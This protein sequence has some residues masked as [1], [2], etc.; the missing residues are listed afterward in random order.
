MGALARPAGRRAMLD[1]LDGL[2][3]EDT[4]PLL[5][6]L[7]VLP[8]DRQRLLLEEFRVVTLHGGEVREPEGVH[9]LGQAQVLG[10]PRLDAGLVLTMDR[11]TEA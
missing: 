9:L 5:G 11:D 6:T 8:H 1:G 10:D 7:A 4:Q 2:L 3:R